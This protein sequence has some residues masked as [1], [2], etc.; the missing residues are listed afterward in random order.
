V[1]LCLHLEAVIEVETEVGRVAPWPLVR[2]VAGIGALFT[3][4]PMLFERLPG[5]APW[6]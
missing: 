2:G 1:E 3:S 6:R 5:G 4:A